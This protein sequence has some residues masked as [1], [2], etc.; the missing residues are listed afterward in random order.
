MRLGILQ[1]LV[2]TN[3]N[4]QLKP[5]LTLPRWKKRDMFH[6]LASKMQPVVAPKVKTET[7]TTPMYANIG[8]SNLPPPINQPNF[9][10]SLPQTENSNDK[11][12]TTNMELLNFDPVDD[13]MLSQVLDQIEKE[14]AQTDPDP[15]S[16]SINTVEKPQNRPQTSTGTNMQSGVVTQYNQ[17]Q[18]NPAFLPKMFFPNSHVTINYTI[19]QK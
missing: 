8:A 12:P 7:V 19:N 17:S 15:N 4:Q 10:I 13:K 3:Q 5:T 14:Q 6:T 1:Q 11:F 9:T 2:A 16:T 18:F